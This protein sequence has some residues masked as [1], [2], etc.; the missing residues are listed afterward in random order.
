MKPYSFIAITAF[1]LFFIGMST[2]M[3]TYAST[4]KVVTLSVDGMTTDAC[5]VLLKSAVQNIKGVK[6]V[7]AS[8]EHK[9]ATVEFDEKL[10]S[11]DNIQNII[12][13]QVGFSTRLK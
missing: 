3:S 11:L 1:V 8:L 4:D 13:T 2:S 5:P 6:K 12:E 7:E 10:T 9:S